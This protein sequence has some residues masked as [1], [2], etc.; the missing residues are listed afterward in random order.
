MHLYEEVSRLHF[1]EGHL[2][3][4]DD[5]DATGLRVIDTDSFDFRRIGH[6]ITELVEGSNCILQGMDGIKPTLFH[7]TALSALVTAALSGTLIHAHVVAHSDKV[8]SSVPILL[9]FI[10]PRAMVHRLLGGIAHPTNILSERNTTPS[11]TWHSRCV[12]NPPRGTSPI[13]IP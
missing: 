10:L 9:L 6:G 4:L 8:L 11:S 1:W 13:P 2:E 5:L 12:A 3:V 7:P